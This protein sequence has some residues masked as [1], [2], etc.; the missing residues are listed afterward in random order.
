[1]VILR[2]AMGRGLLKHTVKEIDTMLVSAKPA[3]VKAVDEKRRGVRV[4]IYEIE[5]ST[6][7]RPGTSVASSGTSVNEHMGTVGDAR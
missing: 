7:G 1:M 3:P 6:C 5:G 2:V 4:T